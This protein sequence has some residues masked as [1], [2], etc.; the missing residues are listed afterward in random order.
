MYIMMLFNWTILLQLY[1]YNSVISLVLQDES[2]VVN[3]KDVETLFWRR[4]RCAWPTQVGGVVVVI[5]ARC[6]TSNPLTSIFQNCF[7]SEFSLG[8]LF[9]KLFGYLCAFSFSSNYLHWKPNQFF[10]H[11]ASQTTFSK[12]IPCWICFWN[13]LFW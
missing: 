12:T 4:F 6:C 2:K 9:R 1:R 7:N 11:N 8:L 13:N 5:V 3:W 10:Q